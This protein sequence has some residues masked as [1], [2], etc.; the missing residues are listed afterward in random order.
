MAERLSGTV[1]FMF[2]DIEGSTSLLKELGRDLYGEVLHEQQRLIREVFA[3]HKGEEIDTQGDAFFAAFRSAA[4]AVEAA[5]AIQRALDAHEWPEGVKVRV[6]IGIHSGEA[7]ASGERYVG[8]SVH[9]A[10]RVGA[11][12]HG[13]QILVSDSTRTLVEDDLP[14]GLFLRDL[15]LFQLK[16]VERPERVSQVAAE[17]LQVD[18]PPLKAKR[19]KSS[20]LHRRALLIAVVAGAVAAVG[21]ISVFAFGGGSSSS[22]KPEV[23]APVSG[24]SVGVFD[25][26]HDKLRGQVAVRK[27]PSAVTTGLGAVW[28]ANLNDDSISQ[29]DPRTNTVEQTI[30]VGNGPVR[31]VVGGGFV[32]VANSL[33]GSVWQIDPRTYDVVRKF[34]IG[35]N[36]SDLTYGNGAVWVADASDKTLRRI[37][38]VKETLGPPIPVNAGA[39]AL[40]VGF[41]SLWVAS[42]AAGTITRI[43]PSSGNA[44]P[45]NVGNGPIAITT[46]AGSV[47][48]ANSLDGTV[49]RIDPASNSQL[50]VIPVGAGPSAMAVAPDGKTVWVANSGAGTLSRIDTSQN[51]TVQTVTTG[52]HPDGVRFNGDSLYFAVRATGDTHRGGTLRVVQQGVFQFDTRSDLL[53]PAIT[54]YGS[55]WQLLMNTNDGLVTFQ[56]AGGVGGARLVPDL[57]ISLPP[58]TD[59]G[60]VYT[61]Q[62]RPNIHYS[63]GALVRPADFKRAIERSLTNQNPHASGPGYIYYTGIVGG[64]A[65]VKTPKRCDLSKG[66]VTG[67]NTVSFHLTAPDPEFLYK[68]ALPT[69]DAEPADTPLSPRLPLPATGPYEISGFRLRSK[70]TRLV[71]TLTRNPHFHE[72]SAAAQPDGYPDRMVLEFE[73]RSQASIFHAVARGKADLTSVYGES[74]AEAA[75]LQT[76]YSA[77]LHDN[78]TLATNDFFLNTRVAP[79]N[80][81]KARQ[82]VAYAVDRNRLAVLMGG[83]AH[84]E[85]T[86]QLIPPEVAGYQRYCPYTIDPRPDGRYTGPDLAKARQLVAASGTKGQ[87][88]VIKVGKPFAASSPLPGYLESVL[89]ELGYKTSIKTVTRPVF[90][91]QA[92]SSKYRWQAIPYGWAADY[93]AAA[94]FFVTTLTCHSF[95]PDSDSNQNW[96]EFCDPSIDAQ[97]ARARSLEIEDPQGAAALWAKIDRAVVDAAPWVPFGVTRILDFTSS[98]VGNYVYSIWVGG[99]LLDQ[100]WVR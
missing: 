86:C 94:S 1:T 54:Y 11:I 88:V 16:D 48:V 53:D 51:R 47:W 18:F 76:R 64:A 82:A 78:P 32:W 58:P 79:F 72:W 24:D 81:L 62:L 3:E 56:R 42:Q 73:T 85:P 52:G 61:F 63:N 65:C 90:Q 17:G 38:P 91:Q 34:A 92:W 98:R 22:L 15:G 89:R 10:A 45:I 67:A 37:D 66:I 33:D 23:S 41:G 2:T 13:G 40:A 19:I 43:D 14:Q 84:N 59:H 57:A 50:A 35:G 9:R 87:R 12:G 77:Q 74:R 28:A 29:I 49:S 71:I 95:V 96:A 100:M 6:R 25:L 39:D 68:L 8:F 21:A 55:T 93:P 69:A 4:D 30:P 80:R 31:V 27:Q 5:V 60:K 20:P 36:P 26:K 46:G 99:V 97:M 75:A 83:R 70:G 7:A 44:Q